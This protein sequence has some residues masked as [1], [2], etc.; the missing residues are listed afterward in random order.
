MDKFNILEFIEH[1][2]KNK[3]SYILY[4]EIIIDPIGNII[5]AR[6]SHQEAVLKYAM[7]KENKTRSEIMSMIPISY[8]PMEWLIDKYGLIAVWYEGYK[9]GTYKK[10]NRFQRRSLCLL[11]SSGLISIGWVYRTEEYGLYLKRKAMGIE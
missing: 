8:A 5:E 2:K 11:E 1:T 3:K 10:P 4:C 7:E 6:P 9:Y